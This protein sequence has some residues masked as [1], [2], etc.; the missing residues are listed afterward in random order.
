[1]KLDEDL[2]DYHGKC[3][4]TNQDDN[5]TEMMRNILR[6]WNLDANYLTIDDEELMEEYA[7]KL[8]CTY[9]KEET[10]YAMR[11]LAMIVNGYRMNSN[12]WDEQTNVKES[13]PFGKKGEEEKTGTLQKKISEIKHLIG[14]NSIPRIHL[15]WL[16]SMLDETYNVPHPRRAKNSHTASSVVKNYLL[17]LE[18]PYRS[19]TIKEF[20]KKLKS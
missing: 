20:I 19:D 8:F 16:N 18:L 11:M 17:R 4:R 14:E 2:C 10:L 9:K 13:K 3:W 12:T 7:P 1:M 5:C 15:D 6:D